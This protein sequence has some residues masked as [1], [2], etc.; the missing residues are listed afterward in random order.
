[1]STLTYAAVALDLGTTSV[2]GGLLDDRGVLR[3]VAVHPAPHVAGDGGR[4]ESDVLA[5]ASIAEQV[6][7]ECLALCGDARP[8]L[9]L[10][11]QRSSFLIWVRGTGQPVTPLISWQDARGAASCS[12]LRAQEPLIRELTGLRLTPYYFAPKLRALLQQ[13]PGWRK[14]LVDGEW[15]AGTLDTFLLWRWSEGAH[16]LTDASMAA[17]T[18]LLD[19]G[20]QAWSPALCALFDIPMAM[21]P[22]IGHSAGLGLALDNGLTLSASIADQSAA[23]IASVGE[24]GDAA[25]VNLGSGGFVIRYLAEGRPGPP[26]YLRT[27]AHQT[28]VPRFAVEGT[29]NSIAA[30]LAPYPVAG[31]DIADFATR[32]IFCTAEPSGLGAP[33]FRRDIGLTFSDP[34]TQ[35]APQEIAVLLL[36]AITFRVAR[37]VEEFHDA[38]PIERVYLSGGLSELRCLQQGIARLVPCKAYRLMQKEGSLQG[39][40]WLASGRVGAQSAEAE[41]IVVAGESNALHEKYR[42]WKQWLDELLGTAGGSPRTP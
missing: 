8:P 31:C 6:L 5:Y 17:R 32:D 12:E 26:G 3:H 20:A 41:K 39:A 21:L 35:L 25:L 10:S 23:L 42:R 22:A 14:K 28:N 11:C 2:K 16:Y 27:L 9:G 38:S 30:A 40:A 37:I 24:S 34:V 33:Y 1:M 36:E 19:V 4:Y 7:A 13:H 18:L 29:L 15:L